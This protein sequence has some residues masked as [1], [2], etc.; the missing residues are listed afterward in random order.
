MHPFTQR[1]ILLFVCGIFF[2]Q[3]AFSEQNSHDIRAWLKKHVD[4]HV[5]A[6]DVAGLVVAVVQS[7]GMVLTYARSASVAEF[8][9]DIDPDYSSVQVA[10]ISK[11]FT[12]LAMLQLVEKGLINLDAPVARYLPEYADMLA[13]DN[14]GVRIRDLFA[15]RAGFEPNQH[16]MWPETYDQVISLSQY[17]DEGRPKRIFDAGEVTIYSNYGYGLAGLVIERVTGQSYED[18]TE[19][20]LFQPLAMRATTARQPEAGRESI[21][22]RGLENKLALGQYESTRGFEAR[23]YVYSNNAPAGSVSASAADM[24]KFMKAFLFKQAADDGAVITPFMKDVMM[25]KLFDDRPGASDYGMGVELR[26]LRGHQLIGHEGDIFYTKS[27][28]GLIPE[29][30]VGVFVAALSNDGREIAISLVENTLIEMI[31][32]REDANPKPNLNTVID[33]LPFKQRMI[34]EYRSHSTFEKLF[35]IAFPSYS[36]ELDVAG[37]LRINGNETGFTRLGPALFQN[38]QSGERVFLQTETSGTVKRVYVGSFPVVKPEFY[39]DPLVFWAATAGAA[40]TSLIGIALLSVRVLS[41]RKNAQTWRFLD[42]VSLLS[43]GSVFISVLLLGYAIYSFSAGFPDTM[44]K[45]PTGSIY[46]S[47]LWNYTLVPAIFVMVVA[48][49]LYLRSPQAMYVKGLQLASIPVFL[50]YV[51]VLDSWNLIGPQFLP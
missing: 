50:I 36:V 4:E 33:P 47:V 42:T 34:F 21:N 8:P 14:G 28:F 41:K 32:A 37:T 15:H 31:G 45:Y 22:I 2:G 9:H 16:P 18:Y 11:T 26:N 27:Y 44:I 39:S 1:L 3:V 24:A 6:N 10:S 35:L 49:V 17:I 23:P 12:A 5:E 43:C 19:Q 13:G 40:I 7:D 30:Q 20:N 29:R 38:D 51:T 25:T 46:A 48:S